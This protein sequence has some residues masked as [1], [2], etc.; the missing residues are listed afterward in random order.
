MSKWP[1]NKSLSL[2]P[3]S[4][5]HKA[6]SRNRRARYLAQVG[7]RL[8]SQTIRERSVLLQGEVAFVFGTADLRF[9]RAGQ[10]E[11]KSTL[12]YTAAYVRGDG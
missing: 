4:L 6:C 12:R 10:P 8:A 7:F 5:C 2:P 11:T 1:P 9:A 3:G